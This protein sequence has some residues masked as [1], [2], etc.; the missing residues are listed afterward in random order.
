MV[1]GPKRRSKDITQPSPNS[2]V[3][4][5]LKAKGGS[6]MTPEWRTTQGT[7]ETPVR[8]VSTEARSSPGLVPVTPDGNPRPVSLG[9]LPEVE[10]EANHGSHD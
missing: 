3:Y 8:P 2:R 10:N 4:R 6:A 9:W 1:E 7:Q 5:A